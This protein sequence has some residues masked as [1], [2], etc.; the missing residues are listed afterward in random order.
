MVFQNIVMRIFERNKTEVKKKAEEN[1]KLSFEN[2]SFFFPYYYYYYY[3]YY[4]S[5]TLQ[6]NAN[7]RLLN[8]LFPVNFVFT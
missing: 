4:Y 7:L 2:A 5:M 8:G 1:Y 3:Y 6:S